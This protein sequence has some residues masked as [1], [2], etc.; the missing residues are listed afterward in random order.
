MSSSET[1]FDEPN[2]Q[3]IVG[4]GDI[5]L[6]RE[7]YESLKQHASEGR[8]IETA[9]VSQ[10]EALRNELAL[11]ETKVASLETRFR[12]TLRERE[13]ATALAGRPLV[14]GAATQLI[15]LW[16]DDFDV[17]EERG[18]YRVS[19]NDGRNV[20]KA[21]ADRLASPEY[22]H[23]CLPT[24]RGG[25]PSGELARTATSSNPTASPKTLGEAILTQWRDMTTR[26]QQPSGPFGLGRR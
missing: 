9:R 12:E 19:S 18:E 10:E 20:A 24:S 23:F 16:R 14:A 3:D 13:L 15:K 2:P 11:R 4:S 6:T 7:E 5:T 25:P 26:S 8:Q 21:V 17:Y 1:S 22:A